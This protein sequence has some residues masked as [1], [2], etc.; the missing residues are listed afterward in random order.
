MFFTDSLIL[1]GGFITDVDLS[2]NIKCY[3]LLENESESD[4]SPTLKEEEHFGFLFAISG[5]TLNKKTE[6]GYSY[7]KYDWE[8]VHK[9]ISTPPPEKDLF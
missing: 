3:D 2:V 1:H 4:T 9:Q 5:L 7:P 6:L 8:N